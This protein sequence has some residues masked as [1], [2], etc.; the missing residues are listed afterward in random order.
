MGYLF[1]KFKSSASSHKIEQE[2]EHKK[3]GRKNSI[4]QVFKTNTKGCFK[5][6]PGK[7]V[8]AAKF[9]LLDDIYEG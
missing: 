3:I 7:L 9:G 5:T 2:R 4:D 1:N 6:R 8:I